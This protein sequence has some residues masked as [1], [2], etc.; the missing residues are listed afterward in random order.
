LANTVIRAGIAYTFYIVPYFMPT[1]RKLDKNI[2]TLQKKICG[3]PICTPNVA[4]QSPYDLFGLEAF[5]IKNAYLT[6]IGKQLQNALK[7]KGRLGKIYNGR[8]NYVLAKYGGALTPKGPGVF[9]I[10]IASKQP[11]FKAR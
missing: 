5:S 10:K 6:C 3:L 4:T 2:I 8:T 9:F 11:L 7:K 1:I